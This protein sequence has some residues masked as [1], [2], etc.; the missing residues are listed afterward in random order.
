MKKIKVLQLGIV[1][2]LLL[3]AVSCRN[4]KPFKKEP[5]IELTQSELMVIYENGYLNGRINCQLHSTDG[6]SAEIWSIDS[7]TMSKR[8]FK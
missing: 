7:A 2:I 3:C 4:E 1:A 8:F 6:K 5:T